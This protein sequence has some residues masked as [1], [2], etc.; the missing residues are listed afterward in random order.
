MNSWHFDITPLFIDYAIIFAIIISLIIDISLAVAIYFIFAISLFRHFRL[1]NC[2]TPFRCFHYSMLIG[3]YCHAIDYAAII[4]RHYCF[5]CFTPFR[6]Y[7]HY[8][9]I[10]ISLFQEPN[11]QQIIIDI[12]FD[13]FARLI[14]YYFI[15]ISLFRYYFHIFATISSTP[16]LA[17]AF[18][19]DFSCLSS[20]SLLIFHF[21]TLR[22]MTLLIIIISFFIDSHFHFDADYAI[23]S[24][25]TF[26]I[27]IFH[28]WWYAIT[29]LALRQ[30]L[31]RH[32]CHWYAD[33][34][35]AAFFSLSF[36][37]AFTPLRRR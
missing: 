6:H 10:D 34:H 8:F 20:F 9:I 26:D 22:L 15:F 4:R 1:A 12:I 30:L 23:I 24:I 2:A 28:Y 11:V 36:A 29:P 5:D 25:D 33:C 19:I 35:Y 32:W 27:S 16:L 7:W 14:D 13:I 31:F 37:I 3:Y 21:D 17:I 18:I